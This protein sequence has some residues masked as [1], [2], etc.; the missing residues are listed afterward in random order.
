M[1]LHSFDEAEKYI[2]NNGIC[3]TIALAGAHDEPALSALI[4]AKR[5]GIV[6]G[7]L[8]GEVDGI[9]EILS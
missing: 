2:L 4:E 8:I 5:K 9:R 7:I 1:L 3:K 6:K